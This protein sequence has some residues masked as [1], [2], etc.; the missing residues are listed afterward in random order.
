[1]NIFIKNN[2]YD[3]MQ[4]QENIIYKYTN[5][6]NINISREFRTNEKLSQYQI[7]NDI[8]KVIDSLYSGEKLIVSEFNI[9]GKSSSQI[10]RRMERAY[11]R[12]IS[13]YMVKEHILIDY[14]NDKLFLIIISL[15]NVEKKSKDKKLKQADKTRQKNGTRLGRKSGKKTKSMFDKHKKKIMK[16][17]RQGVTKVRILNE[18]KQ[19]DQGLKDTS[20]QA[21]GQYIRKI[22]RY[23]NLSKIKHILKYQ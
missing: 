10:L 22:E 14:K 1:M 12:S 7:E 5:T 6:N 16:L 13:I 9:L 15:L 18:I 19:D 3:F 17:H 4:Q 11:S 20:A 23:K 8:D 21:L 2:S